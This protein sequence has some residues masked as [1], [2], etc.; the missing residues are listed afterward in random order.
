M[1]SDSSQSCSLCR[2]KGSVCKEECEYRQIFPGNRYQEF[3]KVKWLFGLK[4]ML[5]IIQSVEANQRQ[6]AADSMFME[7]NAWRNHPVEGALGFASDL[8]SQ[9]HS[10]FNQLQ[11]AKQQ[12]EIFKLQHDDNNNGLQ[13]VPISS[14]P[15]AAS[16]SSSS[17]IPVQPSQL[18][19]SAEICSTIMEGIVSC[20]E[21]KPLDVQ[22]ITSL[23]QYYRRGRG[24]QTSNETK[25]Q[26]KDQRNAVGRDG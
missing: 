24:R 17:G 22:Q 5:T 10:L 14:S 4:N 9:I 6:V 11:A 2:H 16:S 23:L 15:F 8:I 7:A 13:T 20:E 21:V 1:D 3:E 26:N 12:L 19:R 18:H 25:M